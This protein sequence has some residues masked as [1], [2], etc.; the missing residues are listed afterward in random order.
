MVSVTFSVTV[1]V[2]KTVET[3]GFTGMTVMPGPSVGAADGAD[4]AAA[5]ADGEVSAEVGALSALEASVEAGTGDVVIVV[6]LKLDVD[7]TAVDDDRGVDVDGSAVEDGRGV[8]VRL[9]SAT[10]VTAL[11][12]T[13][14]LATALLVTALLV[15]AV[16][17][18]MVLDSRC[19]VLGSG[20]DV[21]AVLD[22]RVMEE[23]SAEAVAEAAPGRT[24]V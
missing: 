6:K 3:S 18:A 11:L 20:E 12:V 24:V 15:T 8:D 7:G 4:V 17:V 13:A 2:T 22:A 1:A 19:D 23:V 10:L 21:E 9:V 14:L 5:G 16:L